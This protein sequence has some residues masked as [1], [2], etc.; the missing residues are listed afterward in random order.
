MIY[1][2]RAPCTG[3][4]IFLIRETRKAKTSGNSEQA[5]SHPIL[6]WSAAFVALGSAAYSR[7]LAF[8]AVS[9]TQFERTE[10]GFFIF[11]PLLN[12]RKAN[13]D[14][15]FSAVKFVS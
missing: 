3:V 11:A 13:Q 12:T 6:G 2:C 10:C 5:T 14:P 1:S 15:R 8:A 4:V 9:C 7:D